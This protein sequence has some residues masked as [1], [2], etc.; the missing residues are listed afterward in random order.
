M[1]STT[2]VNLNSAYT[3]AKDKYTAALKEENKAQKARLYWQRRMHGIQEQIDEKKARQ[4]IDYAWLLTAHPETK[5]KSKL[6]DKHLSVIGIRKNKYDKRKEGY[7]VHYLRPQGAWTD[8]GETALQIA[9][10]KNDNRPTRRVET[11]LLKLIPY[12]KPRNIN[13]DRIKNVIVVEIF[14]KGLSENDHYQLLINP[15]TMK[16]R[17]N[18]RMDQ[19]ERKLKWYSLADA[20]NYIQ[21]NCH[22]YHEDY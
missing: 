20:L 7:E 12:M 15:K 14:E 16:A 13:H 11:K 19:Y 3:V 2:K 17:V 22:Y 21:K 18:S 5:A 6:Q 8:T 10:D 1:A 4:K 9:L